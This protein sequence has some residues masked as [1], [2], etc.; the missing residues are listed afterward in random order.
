MLFWLILL[1]AI[2]T[3]EANHEEE[4]LGEPVEAGE[5]EGGRKRKMMEIV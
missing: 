4:A 1:I 5:G 3:A 2:S